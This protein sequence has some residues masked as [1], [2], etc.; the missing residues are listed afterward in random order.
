MGREHISLSTLS[1]LSGGV[2]GEQLEML[3]AR[4][5]NKVSN[6]SYE[7]QMM[8]QLHGTAYQNGP[9]GNSLG[10]PLEGTV[11]SIASLSTDDVSCA[12]SGVTGSNVC[13]VGT[14]SGDHDAFV[15]EVDKV[16]GGL[17]SSGSGK[18]V[19]S[20]GEKSVFIGSDVR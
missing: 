4:L 10:N 9:S 3:K 11:D 16:L 15:E 14:G 20:L 6:N 17:Q 8:D 5:T 7:S 13:V 12:F 18:E 2:S 19:S 1:P